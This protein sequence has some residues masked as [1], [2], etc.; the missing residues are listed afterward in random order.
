MGI[1]EEEFL[2][3]NVR[4]SD[5]PICVETG[6]CLGE[7]T[8]RIRQLFP[9]VYTI[10]I[11]PSLHERAFHMFDN[12]TCILGDS[13]VE[14][15]RLLPRLDKPTVF[16][17]DAHWSGDSSTDWEH[18]DFS[19]YGV[20]TGKR[21]EGT[22]WEDQVPLLDEIAAIVEFPHRCVIYV[23]DADKFDRSGQ[24]LKD[25]GFLGEDWSGVHLK[26]IMVALEPRMELV[27]MNGRQ[28]V[29]VLR[30]IL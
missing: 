7:S 13:A 11:E 26:D 20:D 10:E 25:K 9:R 2:A 18:S 17:L 30:E 19:G 22:S 1:F 16:F 21:G 27:T 4:L 23:D 15:K 12:V 6:T 3:S 8:E 24:G 14:L 5:Y 29:V 28:L